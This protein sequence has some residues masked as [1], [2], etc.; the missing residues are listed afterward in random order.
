LWGAA[1]LPIGEPDIRCDD[2]ANRGQS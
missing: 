2:G 1:P